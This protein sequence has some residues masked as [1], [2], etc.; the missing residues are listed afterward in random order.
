MRYLLDT[1]ICIYWFKGIGHIK[2]KIENI[3]IDDMT[4]SSITI[5]ELLYGTINRKLDS[6]KFL[7]EVHV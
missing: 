1:N 5:G 7:L 2:A 6:F 3:D 4:V